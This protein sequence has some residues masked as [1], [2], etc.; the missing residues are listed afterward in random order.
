MDDIDHLRTPI[1]LMTGLCEK[2][3]Y[4]IVV[5]KLLKLRLTS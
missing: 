1:A 5:A 4:L 2:G 3:S